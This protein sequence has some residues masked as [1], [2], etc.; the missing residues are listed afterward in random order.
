MITYLIYNVLL[1]VIFLDGQALAA[2]LSKQINKI[3]KDLKKEVQTFNEVQQSNISDFQSPLSFDE[4]KDPDADFWCA[5]ETASFSEVPDESFVPL[6]VKR[7]AVELCNS[8]D[9]SKEE[10]SLIMEEMRNTCNYF[11]H[12]HS[13][14]IQFLIALSNE[15]RLLD[16]ERGKVV[17]ARKKLLAIESTLLELRD[18]FSAYIAVDVPN[19]HLVNNLDF[20]NDTDLTVVEEEEAV[21]AFGDM[22]ESS[23]EV[24]GEDYDSAS[25]DHDMLD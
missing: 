1:A 19:L 25:D 23:G 5:L 3:T 22:S 24:S 18:Q 2:R 12:Q 21:I 7:K 13:V 10:Q 17:F 16:V 15:E 11:T 8:L 9:R 6:R 20:E 14:I 4:I